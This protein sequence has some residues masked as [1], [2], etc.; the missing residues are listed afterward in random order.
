MTK[1]RDRLPQLDDRLFL[2]DGGLE[3]TLVFHDGLELPCFAAYPLLE[4]ERGWQRLWD[5][6]AR[7]IAL[8]HKYRTGFVLET[9]TWRA[10]PDWAA[11]LGHDEAALAAL[12]ARSVDFLVRLRT[13]YE[14]PDTP[15]VVSGCLGPRGDGYQPSALMTP[16]EAEAYHGPQVRNLAAAG[17]DMVSC[18]TMTNVAE[19]IGIARAAKAAGIPLACS[20]TVETDG[21]LP[22]GTDL[23]EAI[24]QADEA[25][26]RSPAYY[27]VNCAHPTHFADELMSDAAWVKRIRGLRGNA[28]RL[29]HAELDAATEL[30]DGDPQ[31]FGEENEALLRRNRH[32]CVLGGC[33]GTDHRHVDA[34]GRRCVAVEA[35]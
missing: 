9:V 34:I 20:F 8:A 29:S 11:K 30:D 25:T 35:A 2:T 27:M 5:Y 23:E 3:T 22:D 16:E 24:G 6:Y 18:F 21:R 12:H 33:C 7:Y 10:N 17:A 14:T 1:Y 32:L 31:A 4:T 19:A 15:M 28:S 13:A 26:G